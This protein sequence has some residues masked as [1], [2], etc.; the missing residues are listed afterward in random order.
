MSHGNEMEVPRLRNSTRDARRRGH[1]RLVDQR[2]RPSG[3]WAVKG[4]AF[5]SCVAGLFP[6]SAFSII[7]DTRRDSNSSRM[8]RSVKD[9]DFRIRHR[10][11]GHSF[12]IECKFRSS[13]RHGVISWCSG[14]QQFERYKEFQDKVRPERVYVVVG[15]IGSP[16]SPK[17]MY[18]IPL[19]EIT[20]PDLFVNE[21]SSY[22]RNP[23]FLFV[24]DRGRL[25]LTQHNACSSPYSPA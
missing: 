6:M 16:Y 18:C 20:E 23:P 4:T 14:Q 19:D 7:H 2:K 11:S 24:Y 22:R 15:L 3:K 25:H 8:P 5:E 12:W 10:A 21:V 17:F 13:A 1:H 9:P